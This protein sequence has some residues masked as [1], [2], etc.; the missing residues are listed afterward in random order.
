MA[1][2]LDRKTKRSPYDP[3]QPGECTPLEDGCFLVG[4]WTDPNADPYFVDMND[5]YR[6]CECKDF[7]K[8]VLPWRS[9]GVDVEACKHEKQARQCEGE[10]YDHKSGTPLTDPDPEPFSPAPATPSDDEEWDMDTCRPS[11]AVLNSLVSYAATLDA[12]A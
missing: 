10:P 4:S 7:E 2:V 1:Q 5:P 9:R 3:G 8:R 12:A 6:T 11:M